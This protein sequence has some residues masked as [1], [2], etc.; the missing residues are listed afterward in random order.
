MKPIR[1]VLENFAGIR[2]GQG[3]NRIEVKL[4]AISHDARIVAITGPNGAGKSTIM[5][6]LHPYRVMPSRASSPSPTAFSFYDHLVA[7]TDGLKELD[8]EHEGKT[9]R[10]VVRMKAAGRTKK[11]EAYLFDLI[12]GR[13]SAFTDPATGITSDGKAETYDRAIE[14]VMGK[15]E[16]FF[17]AIFSAQGKEPI[18]SMAAGEIKSLLSA[19][20]GMQSMKLLSEKAAD[21]VR[22][23][24][25]YLAAKQSQAVPLQQLAAKVEI[26]QAKMTTTSARISDKSQEICTNDLLIRRRIESLVE[27][28]T[29]ATQQESLKAQRQA[30][31]ELLAAAEQDKFLKL[32]QFSDAQ[33]Q[34]LQAVSSRI[35]DLESTERDK[36]QSVALH[37]KTTGD[38]MKLIAM[39]P[40]L[41]RSKAELESNQK[42]LQ[43]LRCKID[44][45]FV[46]EIR[47]NEIST[48]ISFLRESLAGDATDGRNLANAIIAA[49]SVAALINQVPCAGHAF[50]SSC[51]L[52]ANAHNASNE[53]PI[54]QLQCT[55]LR[56][57]YGKDRA[58]LNGIQAEMEAL[59]VTKR[60]L[61]EL[62]DS[63]SIL[64]LNV[65]N[66]KTVLAE[67][68][69]VEA[70]KAEFP[71][72]KECLEQATFQ[73]QEIQARI[74][75]GNGVLMSLKQKQVE[76]K[77]C[78]AK[79]AASEVDRIR[80][81]LD[82]LPEPVDASDIENSK[83]LLNQAELDKN[84]FE[85]IVQILRE[86]Q[87]TVAIELRQA[88]D[89][90]QEIKVLQKETDRISQEVAHWS[91]LAKAF[92][93][94]GIIAMSID[95]AGP[96]ISEICNGLLDDCYG[97]RFNVR[98]GTQSATATGVLKESF[99]IHVEDTIRGENKTLD[100]MSGGEKVWINECLVRA[101]ALYMS[102]SSGVQCSTLFS[103]ESDGPLDETRKRQFMAMKRAVIE[104]GGYEREYIIT[105]TP[106]L[107]EMC[108][109]TL[110]VSTL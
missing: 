86:S 7:G 73:L 8:F 29:L 5:D 41:Q 88:N 76:D 23:L 18:S 46:D 69:R 15:S 1:L 14:C 72:V 104:R 49:Q 53:I 39:E 36:A 50:S 43:E 77:T 108:D 17:T 2:S 42:T 96:R 25:P 40:S 106:E 32:S 103:D 9:Y 92:G 74:L 83:S 93:N 64:N 95:D 55:S 35:S 31:H 61:D 4:D 16:V 30:H 91:L 13:A 79:M 78:F 65:A 97:G 94:D 38:L 98:I 81:A 84:E 34:E 102:E 19:M 47:L 6:N 82:A 66:L 105:Q 59:Q 52:L 85:K 56:T 51:Q 71:A 89:A 58:S 68:P 48:A 107:W 70:A 3:K 80:K 63:E 28:Q 100:D 60:K 57:K 101:M 87:Q 22:G 33:L 62:K 27:M 21:V 75:R 20:M 26:L 44:D 110:D 109:A 54:K 10:S 99:V 45:L 12:D 67:L 90:N 24:K 11:Q 37:T